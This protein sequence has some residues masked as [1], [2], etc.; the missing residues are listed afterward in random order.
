MNTLRL[1]NAVEPVHHQNRTKKGSCA[2]CQYERWEHLPALI[3]FKFS[4]KITHT[5]GIPTPGDFHP[6][7]SGGHVVP[8]W[9]SPDVMVKLSSLFPC[10]CL[11]IVQIDKTALIYSF[12]ISKLGGLEHCLGAL[13]HQISPVAKGLAVC[14]TW[15][16]IAVPRSIWLPNNCRTVFAHFRQVY[17]MCLIFVK[18]CAFWARLINVAVNCNENRRISCLNLIYFY[19]R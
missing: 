3:T 2:N 6:D 7:R 8:S 15:K 19:Y 11:D 9:K 13:A 4:A 1:D 14:E 10:W 5:P 12:H 16:S 18:N 17:L